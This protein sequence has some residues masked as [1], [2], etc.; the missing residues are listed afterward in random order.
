MFGKPDFVFPEVRLAVFVD[1]CFWHACP[2]HAAIPTTNRLF[3]QRKLCKN[4]ERDRLVRRRL[5][6]SG[7]RVIRIWQHELRWPDKVARR[8]KRALIG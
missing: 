7:W 8:L 2:L 5:R 4:K 6:T 1:G 3:W